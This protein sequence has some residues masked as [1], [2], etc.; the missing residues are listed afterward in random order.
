MNW[1]QLSVAALHR[2]RLICK[3]GACSKIATALPMFQTFYHFPLK[4]AADSDFSALQS[5]LSIA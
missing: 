4:A 5:G 1:F 3:P 2:F